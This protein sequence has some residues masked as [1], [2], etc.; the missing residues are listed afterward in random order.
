MKVPV[1]W[2]RELV[3]IDLDV[4]DLVDVM[5]ANGLE[6][7]EVVRPGAGTSGVRTARVVHRE[8]HP[9]AD[10]LQFVRVTDGDT[11][12]E[13][14]CGAWNFAEG[15]VI[16]H[17]PPGATIPGGMTLEARKLRGI[18]SNGMIL[19]AR[20]LEIAD[21]HTGIMVLPSDT[22]LGVDAHELFPLGEPVI[23]VAV[24]ADRGDHHSILGVARDLAAILGR[25][26]REPDTPSPSGEGPVPIDIEAT[27]GCSH[28][29]GWAVEGVTVGTLPWWLRQRLEACGI[30]SI[31]NVVDVTNYVLLELGQPLHAF[32]LDQ[33]HGP[34]IAVRWARPGERLVTLDDKERVLDPGDLVIADADRAVALAGVMGGADTEVGTETTRVLL[35]AA[36]FDPGAVRR[37]SRRLHLVSEASMRF[38][39]RVDPAGAQRAAA[40]AAALLAE[41][42]GGR[43]GGVTSAGSPDQPRGAIGYDTARF[44]AFLGLA[45]L[46]GDAQADLLRRA[47]CAVTDDG[48]DVLE[49]VPPSWRGDLVRPADLAEEVARLY[50]Y[51]RIPAM[52]PPVAQRGGLTPAQQAERSVGASARAG[53]F[54]EAQTRPFVGDDVLLGVLP[55]GGRVELA[56]PLA[57]D[58]SRMRP[59]MLEGLLGAVRRNVGQGRPGVAVYEYG[60]IFRPAGGPL[61]TVL[62][63]FGDRW[64]WRDDRDEPL[65][66]QPRTI[67]L[68]AQGLRGGVQWLDVDDTWSVEDLLAVC[69]ELVA[70]LAPPDDATWMLERRAVERDGFHPGRTATL[71]LRGQEI[72]I[73]GQLHP[74][75]ATRRDLPEPVVVAELLV[76]PLL[77]HVAH[78]LPPAQATSLVKHPAMTVDVA[79]VAD[80]SVRYDELASAVRAGAGDLLDEL[81]FFDEYRGEQVGPGKRSVAIRL[82]LQAP[83]R[84]LS[85]E[86]ADEVIAAVG[87]EAEV[88]GAALRR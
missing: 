69:D 70:R 80:E 31:N 61:D 49:V 50:G 39:R 57:K 23:D 26:L 43:D 62:G 55:D 59:T 22:A 71:H 24:Q 46:S 87:R 17:A 88:I 45:D 35:E 79:L 85:D 8:P 37:T 25:E 10:K 29:V 20:E 34:R 83:E 16:L 11:E 68:A 18:L 21:D 3:D 2:L 72:G 81:W 27:D 53:G 82:R 32:D 67:G 40:R 15:D 52:L 76:E 42:A 64:Q 56:N 41:L 66:T 28:Y 48:G 73:V 7:E 38:E 65:P 86:D 63:A 77:E 33:L 51:D 44:A 19:S 6:V 13:V 4:D 75:E 5:N 60:R 74:D 9:D 47:G 78:G 36:I 14:V 12:T 84:Q 58:A 30:R 1:S 54:H